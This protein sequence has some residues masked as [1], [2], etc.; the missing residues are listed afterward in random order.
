MSRLPLTSLGQGRASGEA[1]MQH[2]ASEV[3]K[4]VAEGAHL[5]AQVRA[6][7]AALLPAPLAHTP[8]ELTREP[9]QPSAA[10][11]P[12]STAPLSPGAISAA[13]S[14]AA[15]LGEASGGCSA[16]L[17]AAA[18]VRMQLRD[19]GLYA[20]PGRGSAG[21]RDATAATPSASLAEPA[22]PQPSASSSALLW[23]AITPGAR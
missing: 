21:S 14:S 13:L 12:P 1:Q 4:A 9:G 20:S 23:D 16:A 22:C 15:G 5:H 8:V 10:L 3:Q 6:T 11:P 2:L 17:R 19:A 7:L 18:I